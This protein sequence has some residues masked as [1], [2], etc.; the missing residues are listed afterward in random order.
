MTNKIVGHHYHQ[1]QWGRGGFHYNHAYHDG[2]IDRLRY[3]VMM[4]ITFF[5]LPN[6]SRCRFP[7]NLCQVL[8][9]M[10]DDD[11]VFAW[12]PTFLG[13]LYHELWEMQIGLYIGTCCSLF[14][15]VCGLEHIAVA[16]PIGL[17]FD[18]H[19][20]YALCFEKLNMKCPYMMCQIHHH[21]PHSG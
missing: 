9:E 16:R 3:F 10:R 21:D 14:M 1:L 19:D 20:Q 11:R 8:R 15:Q 2:L 5:M 6:A 12:G 18:I 4:V 13:Q 7:W 17:P